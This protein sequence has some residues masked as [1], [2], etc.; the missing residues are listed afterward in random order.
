MLELQGYFKRGLQKKI[1]KVKILY[2]VFYLFNYC[3]A[4]YHTVCHIGC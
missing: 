3:T 4:I 1:E 2:V